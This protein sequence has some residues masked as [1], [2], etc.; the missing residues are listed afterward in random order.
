MSFQLQADDQNKLTPESDF[1]TERDSHWDGFDIA[2]NA[3]LRQGLVAS[4]GTSTG[5]AIVD[6]CQ[7]VTKYNNIVGGTARGP[8]P[9]GCRDID[10]FQ[11]T[12]RGLATYTV[13]KI[14]VLISATVRSQPPSQLTATWQVPLH[15]FVLVSDQE[16][17]FDKGSGE[18]ADAYGLGRDDVIV[19]HRP[20]RPSSNSA[21]RERPGT[22]RG[23]ARGQ[24]RSVAPVRP[25]AFRRVH[26]P[27]SRILRPTR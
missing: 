24:A 21:R 20:P 3:R 4:I 9:R 22:D 17:R 19:L 27:A 12:I 13:P 14:D 8:D 16:R 7:T 2:F 6:T 25:T 15:W 18:I 5:R 26:R 11:T 1:G 23:K 10:P